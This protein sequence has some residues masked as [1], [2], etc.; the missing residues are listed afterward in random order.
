MLRLIL[1]LV[2]AAL[3]T[4]C[5]QTQKPMYH[6][7][8]YSDSLY[9]CKKNDGAETMAQHQA[10]LE[11]IITESKDKNMR[12]PPGV[13]AELGYLYSAQNRSREAIG[14]FEQERQT[15]PESAILMDR[16]ISQAEKR[17]SPPE[18]PETSPDEK[19]LKQEKSIGGSKQ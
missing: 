19:A 12:V 17:A 5:V 11:K 14:L 1:L 15:Y 10:V 16:L 8:N 9:A 7:C 18:V 4:G 13:C 3:A 6:W 2:L